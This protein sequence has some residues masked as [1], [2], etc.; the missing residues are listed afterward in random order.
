MKSSKQRDELLAEL[1]RRNKLLERNNDLLEARLAKLEQKKTAPALEQTVT[2]VPERRRSPRKIKKRKSSP[3]SESSDTTTPLRRRL[4]DTSSGQR[5]SDTSSSGQRKKKPKHEQNLRKIM[6]EVIKLNMDSRVLA[7]EFHD[8]D[9]NFLTGKFEDAVR[10]IVDYFHQTDEVDTKDMSLKKVFN[11]AVSIVKK[12]KDYTPVT[13][14]KKSKKSHGKKKTLYRGKYA[15]TKAKARSIYAQ[16]VASSNSERAPNSPVATAS[17]KVVIAAG[18]AEAVATCAEVAKHNAARNAAS[19]AAAA[20]D[21]APARKVA[22][23][24]AR[25]AARNAASSAA[26]A[27][28]TAPTDADVISLFEDD[29]SSGEA[30][31]LILYNKR[32]QQQRADA[33]KNLAAKKQEVLAAAKKKQE[34]K[35]KKKQ[36]ALAAAKKKQEEKEKKKQD[37]LNKKKEKEKRKQDALNRKNKNKK[38]ARAKTKRGQIVSGSP[39]F[40]SYVAGMGA[41]AAAASKT[42]SVEDRNKADCLFKI[43]QRVSGLWPALDEEDGG[44]WYNGV[45][46]SLDYCH[47]TVHIKYDDGDSDDAVHWYNARIMEDDDKQDG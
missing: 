19:S 25:N 28:D 5:L 37:L 1:E 31:S 18:V 16:L 44:G 34:E 36:E 17:M 26:A 32:C 21:T 43:G 27:A 13:R 2:P 39:T 29:S 41:E 38:G 10:P 9:N 33:K 45:V 40:R 14:K 30:E 3:A 6:G 22:R 15:S 4:S 24:T 47:R 11:I 35:E 8:N 42:T 46:I 20:A 12:R 7:R 23:N